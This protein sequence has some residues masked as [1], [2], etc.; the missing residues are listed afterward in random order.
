MAL[1]A[2]SHVSY[3]DLIEYLGRKTERPVARATRV[4]REGDKLIIRLH[5]TDIMVYTPDGCVSLYMGPWNTVTT[6]DR[7]NSML[8]MLWRV[9]TEQGIAYLQHNNTGSYPFKDGI[10]LHLETGQVH[11]WDREVEEKKKLRLQIRNYVKRYVTAL[12]NDKVPAPNIG[13]CWMCLL[14]DKQGKLVFGGDTSHLLSH[15]EE[16]YYVPSLLRNALEYRGASMHEWWMVGS[17][18]D[19]SGKPNVRAAYAEHLKRDRGTIERCLRKYLYR[20]FGMA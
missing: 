20:Q 14:R 13:D 15:M 2:V 9:Y 8:P 18:W 7:I 3:Q 12:I 19:H 4:R 11:G 5:N 1:T 17:K 10:K 6:R 16:N